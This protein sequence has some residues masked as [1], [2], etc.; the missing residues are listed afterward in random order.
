MSGQYN[1]TSN[2][3]SDTL[4]V[5]ASGISGGKDEPFVEY[6]FDALKE[7]GSVISLQ[8]A[9]DPIYNDDML[10]DMNEIS[11]EDYFA[12]I[13]SAI[14]AASEKKA[15]TH[16]VFVAHSF[17]A[18]IATY[19]LGA[20]EKET[21]SADYTLITID[22]DDSD[23]ALKYIDSLN[24]EAR[25]DK[26]QN[27]FSPSTTQYLREHPS[28]HLLNA[29]SVRKHHIDADE[30]GADHEF[31]SDESKRLLIDRILSVTTNA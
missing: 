16:I 2:L 24:E 3:T 15:P 6:L 17:S 21:A 11:V 10:P 8:F 31:E 7:Y 30:V 1:L 20:H 19:Y 14:A 9:N 23:A 29:L 27:P 13:D 26:F 22:N 18:I 28:A 4:Y 5:I 12:C 25:K